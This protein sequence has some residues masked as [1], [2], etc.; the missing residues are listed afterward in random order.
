MLGHDYTYY[1]STYNLYL[2]SVEM[3]IV[4]IQDF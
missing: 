3:Q 1:V 2:L 4:S